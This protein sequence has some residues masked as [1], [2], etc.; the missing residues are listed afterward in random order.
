MIKKIL[1][2]LL[3]CGCRKTESRINPIDL[4]KVVNVMDYGAV[5]NGIA[6]DTKAFEMAMNK[7]FQLK[8]QVYIPNGIF[9]ALLIFQHNA[10]AILQKTR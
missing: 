1:I 8:Q 3:V 4:S 2:L 9:K 7:A 5:G 6:N 10:D